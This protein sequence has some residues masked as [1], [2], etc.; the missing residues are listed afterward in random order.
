MLQYEF[1][2]PDMQIASEDFRII[3]LF[4]QMTNRTQIGWHY[5]SD[6][7]WI[8][9]HIKHWPRD[10]KILDAGGGA[11]GPVQF[12]MAEL[13]FDVTNIDLNLNQPAFAYQKRYQ[14]EY[15]V[16]PSFQ[17]TAYGTFLAG[18]DGKKR[19]RKSLIKTMKQSLPYKLWSARQYAIKH[20]KWRNAMGLLDTRV[21]SVRWFKGN[22]SDISDLPDNTFDAV[23]SLSALEHIH[24][25]EIK[26][27]VEEIK[28]VVKPN[29]RWAVTTSG[30]EKAETWFHKP[31]QGNCFSSR[32]IE[33]IFTASSKGAQDP[34]ETLKKYRGN[35][36]LKQN[37]PEI[38]FK[39]GEYGMPLGKWDPKYIP[40]GVFK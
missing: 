18:A 39:S 11:G 20:E 15:E 30:T 24:F 14:C 16:L 4:L 3:E 32:D 28:R 26:N 34:Q 38:Y 25:A 12:L 27:A 40:V 29:G 1:I 19:H 5:I 8:Y 35:S 31:S 2:D 13:G 37:L 17:N 33:I 21:G 9:S 23:V 10:F 7:T 22:L 6:I 36:Y